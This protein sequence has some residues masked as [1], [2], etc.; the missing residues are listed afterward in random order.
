MALKSGMAKGA[1]NSLII[2]HREKRKINTEIKTTN[3]S[4]TSSLGMKSLLSIVKKTTVRKFKSV[5][6]LW[7]YRKRQPG[8]IKNG[9][10]STA[11]FQICKDTS[12]M[13]S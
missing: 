1:E 13:T 3:R 9:D 7:F 5:K 6:K 8:A 4:V 2:R 10:C 11:D 12:K